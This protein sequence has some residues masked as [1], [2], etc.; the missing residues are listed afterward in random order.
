MSRLYPYG[1]FFLMIV[2]LFGCASNSHV[3]P[4]GRNELKSE[5]SSR[6][7]ELPK[8][9]DIEESNGLISDVKQENN[10]VSLEEKILLKETLRAYIFDEYR[11]SSEY[12]NA[13]GVNWAENFY[14]NLTAEEI[15]I[16]I[17]EYKEMNGGE[18]G[19]LLDQARYLSVKAPIKDNWDELFLDNWNSSVYYDSN[20]I[21][22]MIDKGDTVWI[23]TDSLPFT[24]EKDNY[25]FITLDKRTGYW[26]G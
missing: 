7:I 2:I 8:K 11:G 14:D 3:N 16:V 26:H 5:N 18:Q 12:G 10:S 17:E 25:P 24:V 22:A 4:D 15:W 6:Q 13:H 9:E 19:T 21:G 23:Y 20:K 1:I